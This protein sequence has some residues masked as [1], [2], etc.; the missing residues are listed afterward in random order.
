MIKFFIILFLF[1]ITINGHFKFNNDS[2][3]FKITENS[4]IGTFVGK[5]SVETNFTA[6]YRIVPLSF[7]VNQDS[8]FPVY[9]NKNGFLFTK[10]DIDREKYSQDQQAIV[11]FNVEAS[12]NSV[13]SYCRVNLIIEDMNDNAPSINFNL[14]PTFTR[15]NSSEL[16]IYE[17]ATLNQIVAYVG[18]TDNDFMENGTISSIELNSLNGT[19]PVR[20]GKISDKLFTIQLVSQ[21]VYAN[22]QSFDLELRVKDNGSVFQLETIS[23]LKINVMEINKHRPIFT[24]NSSKIELNENYIS[25]GALFNFSAVDYDLTGSLKFKLENF[26]EYFYLINEQLWQKKSVNQSLLGI[27]RINLSVNVYD[28]IAGVRLSSTFNLKIKI[29]DLNDNKPVIKTLGSKIKYYLTN[30]NNINF[31]KIAPFIV[32]SDLD[33]FQTNSLNYEQNRLN[34]TKNLI[35]NRL[36][37]KTFF[38]FLDVNCKKAFNFKLDAN[39]SLPLVFLIENVHSLYTVKCRLSIWLDTRK[40]GQVDKEFNFALMVS[41]NGAGLNY[42]KTNFKI[43]IEHKQRP[44]LQKN[45]SFYYKIKNLTL[46]ESNYDSNFGP[47]YYENVALDQSGYVVMEDGFLAS[48]QSLNLVKDYTDKLNSIMESEQAKYL[49]TNES[50]ISFLQLKKILF[51]SNSTFSSSRG[52]IAFYLCISVGLVLLVLFLLAIFLKK[53]KKIKNLNVVDDKSEKCEN[54]DYDKPETYSD[55]SSND[56]FSSPYSSLQIKSNYSKLFMLQK[57]QMINYN[58]N[59]KICHGSGS[60]NYAESD[61]GC[62]GS[63]DFSSERESESKRDNNKYEIRQNLNVNNPQEKIFITESYV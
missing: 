9:V 34:E 52:K 42:T 18:I 25:K 47:F 4:P 53:D 49:K 50:E 31:V 59:A 22:V 35:L 62:Y 23:Y 33:S 41:D 24:N 56:D 6:D 40:Y 57:S 44:T 20:L 58:F 19:S 63:S 26:K 27:D 14:V 29:L 32:V 5:V 7:H 37:E 8:N 30:K 1:P 36:N 11:S 17:N 28:E 3:N 38:K 46:H 13:Y 39:L 55:S 45:Q 16:F 2:Y 43:K 51:A 48:N 54:L 10:S 61:E 15:K 21:L 12:A 60:S